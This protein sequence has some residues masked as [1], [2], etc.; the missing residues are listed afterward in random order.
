MEETERDPEK[1]T[2]TLR[3]GVDPVLGIEITRITRLDPEI[4]AEIILTIDQG[5]TLMRETG[6]LKEKV[7]THPTKIIVPE[8][9]IVLTRE[10]ITVFI[11]EIEVTL[12]TDLLIE[13]I[14][15]KE[16]E[17]VLLTGITMTETVLIAETGKITKTLSFR[18]ITEIGVSLRRENL[19]T[20]A[21]I[22]KTKTGGRDLHPPG[23]KIILITDPEAEIN[24]YNPENIT[25]K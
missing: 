14:L 11:I 4:G 24:P 6:I 16:A 2:K 20:T 21:K 23:E 10:I 7:V 12:I 15:M 13:E 8:G 5:I 22:T 1:M 3:I 18:K 19:I 9:E 17:I 25:Q